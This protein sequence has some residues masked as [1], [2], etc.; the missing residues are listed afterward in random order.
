MPV[1]LDAQAVR[2]FADKLKADLSASVD[3][4]GITASGN[5][6]KSFRYELQP[7]R[8]RLWGASYTETAEV[9][10]RPTSNAGDG[11]L[12]R[13]IRRWIDQKGINPKPSANGRPVSKE[14]LAF[15]IA[16]KIHKQGT[17]LYSGTDY[18]GRNKPTGIIQGVINDGRIDS[19]KKQLITSFVFSIKQQ[20][21][22]EFSR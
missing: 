3:R 8:L 15:M 12:R 9:G 20:L 13:A 1:G 11:A 10:R 2:D 7:D 6:A 5:L 14:S 17:R 16:R 21:Q 18:Y 4:S 22:N 19:L